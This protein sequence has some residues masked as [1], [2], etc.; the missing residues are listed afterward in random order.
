MSCCWLDVAKLVI[1]V[2][3]GVGIDPSATLEFF[4]SL[5]FEYIVN[6][7]GAF[8]FPVLG[9]FYITFEFGI[10]HRFS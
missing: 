2:I 10:N 5:A 1:S 6:S 3:T 4:L 9:V 8:T 7:I